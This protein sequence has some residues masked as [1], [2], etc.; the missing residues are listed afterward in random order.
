MEFYGRRVGAERWRKCC[1]ETPRC[2]VPIAQAQTPPPPPPSLLLRLPLPPPSPPAPRGSGNLHCFPS[3]RLSGW[4]FWRETAADGAETPEAL[5]V[6]RGKPGKPGGRE[7]REAR[8]PVL[9]L[10]LPGSTFPL[11]PPRASGVG[12]PEGPLC[13]EVA[14]EC[15]CM[16]VG[17]QLGGPWGWE[18]CWGPLTASWGVPGQPS[19]LLTLHPALHP[20]TRPP[21]SP[22]IRPLG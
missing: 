17:V 21:R 13:D 20:C 3:R 1:P 9:G 5:G 7:G 15:L 4:G 11:R 19:S 10:R 14:G 12:A 6:P 22:C 2:R 16:M 8:R 18:V